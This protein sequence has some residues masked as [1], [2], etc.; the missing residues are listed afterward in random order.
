MMTLYPAE[1][2]CVVGNTPETCFL[3]QSMGFMQRSYW[4]LLVHAEHCMASRSHCRCPI[5]RS[6]L[7]ENLR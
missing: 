1:R 4:R 2:L 7:C 6:V 5:I 3:C